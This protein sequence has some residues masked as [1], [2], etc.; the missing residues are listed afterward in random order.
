MIISNVQDL[1][2]QQIIFLLLQND[3]DLG[4]EDEIAATTAPCLISTGATVDD[5]QSL[6]LAAEGMVVCRS[7]KIN[8]LSA[9]NTLFDCKLL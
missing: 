1:Q 9:V 5:I 2:S 8:I 7:K 3:S 4:A 6:V